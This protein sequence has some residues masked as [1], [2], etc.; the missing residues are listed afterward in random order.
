MAKK[1]SEKERALERLA[2][3]IVKAG[4]ALNQ[5]A[6]AFGELEAAAENVAALD[7]RRIFAKASADCIGGLTS[8]SAHPGECA[9]REQ[10]ETMKGKP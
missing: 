3:K 2:N 10:G 1:R 9:G 4:R 8:L 5:V 6:D 7:L